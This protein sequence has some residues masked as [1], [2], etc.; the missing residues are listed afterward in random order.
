[1]RLPVAVPAVCRDL[2]YGDPV[3]CENLEGGIIC[4]TRRVWTTAGASLVVKQARGAP[5]DFFRL[6]ATALEAIRHDGWTVPAI[7]AATP[8]CLVLED[9]GDRRTR[10][11]DYWERLG[12]A[13]ARLH[14]R[15]GSRYGWHR[16]LY[17]GVFKCDNAWTGDGYA[18][19]ARTRFLPWL[20][21]PRCSAMLD[22]GD[23][24]RLERIAGRLSALIP[25]QG[26]S[27]LHGDL[28][29]G[30][31]LIDHA[32]GPAVIDP[33][34]YFGWPEADL[35][36]AQMFGGFDRRFFD[37]YRECHWLEPGWSE[38]LELLYLPHLL[39]MIEHDCDLAET[40]PWTR[41]VLERFA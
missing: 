14:G 2:G 3:G 19:Y 33:S 23:R 7:L 15:I 5:A 34:P 32:G 13:W 41:R 10:A 20:E 31:L 11:D 28:W 17:Y 26:P 22:A 24:R 6:E 12:R 16:D 4:W 18:F 39:G 8:D 30:N 29:C 40:V 38:R 37:A 1:M 25:P 36:N 21:R 27:L 35:H 9:L